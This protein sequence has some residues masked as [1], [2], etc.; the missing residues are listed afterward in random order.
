MELID[1]VLEALGM[2]DSA[3]AG[4]N[5]KWKL[6]ISPA[7]NHFSRSEEE[8]E[9]G[10]GTGSYVGDQSYVSAQGVS[11]RALWEGRLERK[12]NLLGPEHLD[13]S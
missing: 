13:Y 7:K 5:G 2:G 8:L 1:S 11:G 9:Y 6:P 4:W 3:G 10:S 12:A